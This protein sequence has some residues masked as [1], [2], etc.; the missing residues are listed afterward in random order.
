MEIEF[1]DIITIS[2]IQRCD[3]KVLQTNI[4]QVARDNDIYDKNGDYSPITIS[5]GHDTFPDALYE[6]L[7]GKEIGAKGTVI[8]P[9]EKEYEEQSRDNIRSLNKKEFK[10]LPKIGDYIHNAQYGEG[11]VINMIGSRVVVDFNDTSA[12]KC[13]EFDYE[14]HEVITDPAEQFSRIVGNLV[15]DEYEASF[16]NGMGIISSKVSMVNTNPWDFEKYSCARNVFE[17]LPSLKCVEFREAY[18]NIYIALL[19]E[20]AKDDDEVDADIDDVTESPYIRLGDVITINFVKRGDGEV[21]ETN[22]KQI[23]RDNNIYDKDIDYTPLLI[24]VGEND[25]PEELYDDFVYR[26]VGEKGTVMLFL[27]ESYE[28][29][30]M[31]HIQ[32]IEKKNLKEDTKV[33]SYVTL[34]EYG[35]G[36]V[37]KDIGATFRVDFNDQLAGKYYEFEYEILEKITDPAEQ[38]LRTLKS[39]VEM[40]LEASFEN[41]KGIIIV[42]MSLG[43]MVLW[44][45]KKFDLLMELCSKLPCLD[46]LEFRERY[47]SDFK[48][49][50]LDTI[51]KEGLFEMLK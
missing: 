51:Q 35:K 10:K 12:G 40:E 13:I 18:K 42:E 11:R 29:W 3:G 39:L 45:M 14:I 38:F 5:S 31:E 46:T 2:F 27:D 43:T 32:S 6:E 44:N 8:I 22:I 49:N 33:G 7:I 23:A 37:I 24:S 9:P 28:D 4:E 30:C 50:M 26:K 16:E 47:E 1:D 15:S 25:F 20:L 21:L 17:R 34:Q 36:L 41:G 19:E 48:N